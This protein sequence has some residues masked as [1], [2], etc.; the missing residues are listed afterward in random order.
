MNGLTI[1]LAAIA[2]A[3]LSGVAFYLVFF[4]S[5]KNEDSARVQMRED[6]RQ[7]LD[8]AESK[9]ETARVRQKGELEEKK[10][11]VESAVARTMAAIPNLIID[12]T[13]PNRSNFC[14]QG[15]ASTTPDL[16][17]QSYPSPRRGYASRE[18]R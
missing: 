17:R 10:A 3:G 13:S 15:S 18:R 11:A 12:I 16:V 14:Q 6:F 2:G 1:L 7:L 8:L 9:F 5:H 4:S